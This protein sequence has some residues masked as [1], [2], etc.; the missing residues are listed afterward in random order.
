[1]RWSAQCCQPDERNEQIGGMSPGR[2]A[3]VDG[4]HRRPAC[5]PL[6]TR[7][8]QSSSGVEAIRS[9]S[10]RGASLVKTWK[11]LHC[12]RGETPT[13]EQCPAVGASKVGEG[14]RF[15]NGV[16][17]ALLDVSQVELQLVH[18]LAVQYPPLRNASPSTFMRT[19]ASPE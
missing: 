14:S 19:A 13:W 7:T 2:R 6:R 8:R 10:T 9:D 3:F 1:M 16:Q 17:A 18:G 5:H 15:S 4:G 12:G 11:V